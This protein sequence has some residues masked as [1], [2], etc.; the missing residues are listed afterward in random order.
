MPNNHQ[1]RL[2]LDDATTYGTIVTSV[3]DDV[4][5]ATSPCPEDGPNEDAIC[6][7]EVSWPIQTSCH[8]TSVKLHPSAVDTTVP[9]QQYSPTLTSHPRRRTILLRIFLAIS[10]IGIFSSIYMRCQP[11][12]R[13]TLDGSIVHA[14]TSSSSSLSVFNSARSFLFGNLG[15]FLSKRASSS[16]S[17]T[18]TDATGIV[19]TILLVRH[20]QAVPEDP[21]LQDD[22]RPLTSRGIHDAERLGKYLSEHNIPPPD[23]IFASPS[24]R[25][26]YTLE[27]M[28]RYWASDVPVAFENIL[29]VL[30]FNDYFAFCAGLNF[31][32]H[33]V[34]IVGHNPA[35]LNTAKRLMT[36]Q[37]IEDFPKGGLMEITWVDQPLWRDLVP[38]TGRTTLALSPP[39]LDDDDNTASSFFNVTVRR[40]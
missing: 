29:Y 31:N 34:M 2:R 30:A 36:T 9:P 27:L 25:T 21:F 14:A 5:S 19:R 39:D 22:Q 20:A 15:S 17:G 40:W 12:H 23:W 8:A 33:R 35:I 38:F 10:S 4:L 26:S 11:W 18:T 1:R 24:V 6:H 37:G 7:E 13:M 32:F 16:S 3:R 28:R